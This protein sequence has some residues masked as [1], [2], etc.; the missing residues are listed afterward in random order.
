MRKNFLLTLLGMG[1][2]FGIN[3]YSQNSLDSIPDA[4]KKQA[5]KYLKYVSYCD[6]V[7]QL[8]IVG[9]KF[10]DRTGE[11]KEKDGIKDKITLYHIKNECDWINV[12]NYII[13]T[14]IGLGNGKFS[15][16]GK[17]DYIISKDKESWKPIPLKEEW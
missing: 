13:Y 10:E 4:V 12:P 9:L 14:Q 15:E 6:T 17:F 2:F 16:T 11:N 7:P 1:M 3:A 5:V 8:E